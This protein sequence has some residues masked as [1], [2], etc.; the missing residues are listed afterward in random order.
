MGGTPPDPDSEAGHRQAR[1]EVIAVEDYEQALALLKRFPP[2]VLTNVQA[3]C[4]Q[5]AMPAGFVELTFLQIGLSALGSR[6]PRMGQ[7]R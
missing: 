1:R 3:C 7:R 6:G 2:R 4:E 5:G